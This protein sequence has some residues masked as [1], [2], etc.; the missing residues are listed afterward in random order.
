[1]ADAVGAVLRLGVDGGRPVQFPEH[2]AGGALQVEPRRGPKRYAAQVG[3]SFHEP[4]GG[5]VLLPLRLPAGDEGRAVGPELGFVDVHDRVVVGKEEHHL[6]LIEERLDEGRHV[7]RLGDAGGLPLLLADIVLRQRPPG[8][9]VNPVQRAHLLKDRLHQRAVGLVVPVDLLHQPPLRRQFRQ[10]IALRPAQHQSLP[11]KVLAQEVGMNDDGAVVPVAPLAGEALPTAQ[12]VEVQNIDYVPYLAAVVVDGRAGKAD[13]AVR[14]GGHEAGGRVLLRPR[15]AQ[16]LNLIEDHRLEVVL[17]QRLLPAPQE[18]VVNDV[19]VRLRQ[20]IGREPPDHVHADAAGEDQKALDLPLP[21][22]HQV[23]RH[24]DERRKGSRRGQ[25]GQRLN[26]LAQAHLVGQERPAAAQQERQPL[27]LKGHE[28]AREALRRRLGRFGHRKPR[29]APG[30]VFPR[31]FEGLRP[32]LP[33]RLA[34]LQRVPEHQPV[35]LSDDAPVGGEARLPPPPAL[36]A[37]KQALGQ[38]GHAGLALDDPAL[39]FSVVAERT[40]IVGRRADLPEVGRIVHGSAT[41]QS[42]FSPN[43]TTGFPAISP[44]T[45]ARSVVRS[46]SAVSIGEAR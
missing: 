44:G 42:R 18:E 6:A 5:G 24:H 33:V 41:P 25:V 27:L 11:P 35:E 3:L 17:R 21:V 31:L 38:L 45:M 7:A 2:H 22:A 19:D 29:L 34:D 37:G 43:T 46:T 23:R 8:R 32:S 1:M 13:H 10:H 28:L 39:R 26:G 20:F 16:F 4:R 14:R 12:K 36:A 30:G 15:V 9:V 40:V